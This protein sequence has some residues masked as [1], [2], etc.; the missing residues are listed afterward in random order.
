MKLRSFDN[1]LL[2]ESEESNAH[3]EAV[4]MGLQY[5]GFGYWTDPRTGEVTHQTIK[6]ELQPY[7]ANPAEMGVAGQNA[8]VLQTKPGMKDQST[9]PKM[10]PGTGIAGAPEP[11]TEQHPRGANWNP[12][13]DG[14]NCVNDQ[15]APKDLA[16]DTF[17]GK[18]NYYKWTAGSD[19]SNFKNITV[20]D[21]L[22]EPPAKREHI[23]HS[24]FTFLSETGNPTAAGL[25]AMT[26][27]EK[28]AQMGLTSDGHG[29]YRDNQGNI[30]ARTVN[31]ELQFYEVGGGAVS[32]SDGGSEMAM[33]KPTWTDPTT[34]MAITPP[35][36]PE[37]P[38]EIAAV[39]TATPSQAPAGYERH[40]NKKKMDAYANQALLDD[41]TQKKMETDEKYEA[42]PFGRA[43]NMRMGQ[44]VDQMVNSEDPDEKA[45]GAHLMDVM[46]DNV[47]TNTKALSAIADDHK[48][49]AIASLARMADR[50]ARMRHLSDGQE[51]VEEPDDDVSISSELEDSDGSI[52]Q[53]DNKE[54]Q[55]IMDDQ[56]KDI[57]QFEKDYNTTVDGYLDSLG[58][59]K[60]KEVEGYMNDM[61][62]SFSK[63]PPEKR[64]SYKT[65]VASAY[66]YTGRINSGGGKND[67]GFVD[68][69]NLMSSKDRLLNGYGDGNPKTVKKFVDSVRN[70]KVDESFLE[71]SFQTLPMSLRKSM[72]KKG[73]VTTDKYVSD[74]KADKDIHFLGY[75]DNGDEI[76]G[77]LDNATN[78][79]M[80]A[81]LMWRI[82]LEQ[83]GVDA[84]TGQPL[85]LEAMDLEHVVGFN[86][87][88]NGKPG[89]EDWKNRE[90]NNNF[91]MINSNIN[92]KKSDL[93]MGEFFENQVDPLKDNTEQQFGGV[94]AMRDKQNQIK[95]QNYERAQTIVGKKKGGSG[96]K[97][98]TEATNTTTMRG[99][100]D[101][102][103]SI[104]EE[105]R[106]E[107]RGVASTPAEKKKAT[108]IKANMGSRTMKAMGL[109][110]TTRDPSGR[111][112][113]ELPENVFRGFLISLS[114]AESKNRGKYY[115]G[116]ETAI[117]S[118][119]E[120]RS[121][122]DAVRSLKDQG[123]ISDEVL[124]DKRLGK[125]FSEDYLWDYELEILHEMKSFSSFM[126]KLNT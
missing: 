15:P 35:A 53:V 47:D 45:I 63:L 94:K 32:D 62:D 17:V 76:R 77:G 44:F 111:R 31:G 39:P 38:E 34:G 6:G 26:P 50:E 112:N 16:F 74:D 126:T 46:V 70:K 23:E 121:A 124:N 61:R 118:A 41:I 72:G 67:L 1:F 89:R 99:Y 108:G 57:D 84:Y 59:R 116:W 78:Q 97:E 56:K 64:N 98:L 28:A 54:I 110:R 42:T 9:G 109:T 48:P 107:Y 123:L 125:I 14:D 43:F 86:N 102:D 58:P 22:T 103:D 82:Y 51:Q 18:T 83:G 55:S 12:G 7:S 117:K 10:A 13:P 91:V 2:K 71:S 119:N 95:T 29:S 11:G 20:K 87:S 101:Q 85:V 80:R 120:S 79:E 69:Q 27:A 66:S 21:L 92:Q 25:G 36:Q 60:R 81:K 90:N 104:H 88:T 68:V 24:F 5:Q 65:A 105:L 93:S 40:M 113:I 49:G 8:D 114:G 33:A 115:K 106:K 75:D 100:F 3:R 96:Y 19:G 4:K 37:T 30:V 122:K 73:L 52:E